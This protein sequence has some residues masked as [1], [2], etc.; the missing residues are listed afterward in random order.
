[1]TAYALL[2]QT[3]RLRV[4]DGAIVPIVSGSEAAPRLLVLIWSQLGDFDI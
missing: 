4:S 2:S 3:D 1:M